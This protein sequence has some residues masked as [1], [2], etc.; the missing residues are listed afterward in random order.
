MA[1]TL[2]S[3]YRLFNHRVQKLIYPAITRRLAHDSVFLNYGYE[4]DPPMAI[5][6]DA[7]DEGSRFPTQLYHATATQTDLGGKTVLEVGCGH[8]GGASYLTRTFRPA[9]YTGLDLNAAA[10]DFCRA[11]H[12]Q[13][14]LTFVEGDAQNL[15]FN[16]ESFDVVVSVESSLHYPHF[17]RF[18]AEV[19]RV[20][21]PG[22]HF[23][24]ADLRPRGIEEWEAALAEAPLRILS[25]R[26]I[27]DEVV[28]GIEKYSQHWQ[29][30]IDLHV[31]RLLR[32]LVR[33][34]SGIKGEMAYRALQSGEYSYRMYHLAKA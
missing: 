1:A 25:R 26:V 14:V 31:P 11:T 27:N 13:D 15:P 9:S 19:A 3:L 34:Q 12:Q 24:Y 20:L 33:S 6:L 21:R 5:P 30:M 29:T 2:D 22:G 7:R 8:G 17:P 28:R 32:G 4:E 10:I 16:D 18:L 23:A